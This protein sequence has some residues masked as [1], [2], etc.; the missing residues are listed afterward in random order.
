MTLHFYTASIY[1]IYPI[2]P[3]HP[4]YP[5]ILPSNPPHPSKFHNALLNEKY[6]IF[7]SERPGA[8]QLPI[9]KK[10]PALFFIS[11][12]FLRDHGIQIV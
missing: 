3:I 2:H 11:K 1:P 4:I 5:N 12:N 6:H 9:F 8:E 10:T 7:L